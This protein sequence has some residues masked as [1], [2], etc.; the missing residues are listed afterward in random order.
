MFK[1]VPLFPTSLLSQVCDGTLW[2]SKFINWIE[3]AWMIRVTFH[4]TLFQTKYVLLRVKWLRTTV[5]VVANLDCLAEYFK[6]MKG[7]WVL[8][9][10]EPIRC[11]ICVDVTNSLKRIAI[12]WRPYSKNK[13]YIYFTFIMFLLKMVRVLFGI[14]W[15]SM[16]K[17]KNHLQGQHWRGRATAHQ[18]I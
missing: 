10:T 12:S 17:M 15:T 11:R 5:I 6:K 16:K 18:V 13:L 4:W 7:M 8:T 9:S 14:Q 2:S 3:N 1:L